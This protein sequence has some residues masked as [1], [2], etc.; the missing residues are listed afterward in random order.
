MCDWQDE[1]FRQIEFHKIILIATVLETLPM[2][3]RNIFLISLTFV[4]GT[5][6]GSLPE[7]I[8][9]VRG[10]CPSVSPLLVK[11]SALELSSSNAC[12]A[13]FTG[14]ILLSCKAIDCHSLVQSY[15]KNIQGRSGSV[16]G[17]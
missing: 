14:Q 10:L 16:V 2:N 11:K 3:F 4:S 12:E 6:F 17:E 5:A 15:K 1:K 7:H 8:S 13:K 9:L